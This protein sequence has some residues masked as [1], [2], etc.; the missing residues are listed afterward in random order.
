MLGCGTQNMAQNSAWFLGKK[1]EREERKEEEEIT[2]EDC[3]LKWSQIEWIWFSRR[4]GK[5][6]KKL[7]KEKVKKRKEKKR[8]KI[9]P[10]CLVC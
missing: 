3:S 7:R 8:D 1:E 2:V 6:E 5:G 9:M 10:V 4:L